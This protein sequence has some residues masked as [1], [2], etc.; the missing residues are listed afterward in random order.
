MRRII[1]LAVGVVTAF[2]V[3]CF[4]ALVALRWTDPPATAV[5]AQRRV[6]AWWR[7]RPYQKR[8]VFVPLG[9]IS[10]DL[11]HAVI[12]A[13]DGRFSK[14]LSSSSLCPVGEFP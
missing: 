6:E 13:E 5:Q 4:A 7:H 2:Y 11:Q 1:L 3:V 8:Y 9:R 10:A 14:H 12:S